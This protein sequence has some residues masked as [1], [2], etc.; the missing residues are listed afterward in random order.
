ME[1]S[2]GERGGVHHLEGGLLAGSRGSAWTPA[3]GEGGLGGQCWAR[4]AFQL[5]QDPGK[6]RAALWCFL[7]GVKEMGGL[8]L[9][10]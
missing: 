3:V 1:R 5:G 4:R 10:P 6:P 7:C 8:T 9:L 2:A